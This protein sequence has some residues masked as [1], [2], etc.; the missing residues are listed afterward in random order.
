LIFVNAHIGRTAGLT[1]N[2]IFERNFNNGFLHINSKV[3]S[4]NFGQERISPVTIPL[5]SSELIYI[6]D[7][8]GR[9]P[10]SISSHYIPIPDGLETLEKRY[11]N[12][13]AIT[14]LRD[15]V[16]RVIS[17]YF[18]FRMKRLLEHKLPIHVKYDYRED[19][20]QFFR[21]CQYV[22]SKYGI[23]NICENHQTYFFD[24]GLDISK[25]ISRLRTDFWFVGLVERFDEGL[26]ILKD[27]FKQLG[28]TFN[29]MYVRQQIAPRTKDEKEQL[30]TN[31]IRE[32]I[33]AMNKLD[34]QLYEEANRIFEDKVKNYIGD[35]KADLQQFRKKLNSTAWRFYQNS[36]SSKVRRFVKFFKI[37]E[38]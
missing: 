22:A 14:F 19:M 28:L 34:Q 9:L 11:D 12:I 36:R 38:V 35:L 16:D 7:K 3:I 4:N 27:Y 29:I 37:I 18:A 20:N 1:L 15:P 32:K 25:A 10:E 23:H 17:N 31:E 8:C 24:N 6:I 33:K 30:V 5:N 2:Y 13:K 26:L 21:N